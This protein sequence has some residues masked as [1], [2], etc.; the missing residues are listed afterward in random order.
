MVRLSIAAIAAVALFGT[1]CAT[2]TKIVSEPPGAEVYDAAA[3]KDA[4]AIG[5]TPLSYE[6]KGWIWESKQLKVQAPGH[7]PKTVDIKRS[8][9]DI[10]PAIGSVCLCLTPLLCTQVGGIVLFVGGGM[11]LPAETKVKLDR[12]AAPAE[13]PA[14]PV[15][16]REDD[17]APVVALRY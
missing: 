17:G 9:V 10:V 12:E 16:L 5:K 6:Y 15:G 3:G 11:K 1:G 2:T 7:K 8:E 4:K 14:P 13:A